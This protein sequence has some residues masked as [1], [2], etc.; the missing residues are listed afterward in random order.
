MSDTPQ[1]IATLSQ[2]RDN[3]KTVIVSNEAE[4]QKLLTKT[5]PLLASITSAIKRLE[6]VNTQAGSKK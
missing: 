4:A 2:L 5:A 6:K 3:L 1:L